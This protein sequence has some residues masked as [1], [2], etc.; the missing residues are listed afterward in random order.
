MGENE[1]VFRPIFGNT[2]LV[3]AQRNS[4]RKKVEKVQCLL[5]NAFFRSH[6]EVA[7]HL[8]KTHK[9]CPKC[10]IKLKTAT[11]RKNHH[12]FC[13]RRF[14]L[15]IHR[16][17]RPEQPANGSLHPPTPEK[18]KFYNCVLCKKSCAS[19]DGLRRHQ[20]KCSARRVSKSWCLK[21]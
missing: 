3:R 10:H 11:E 4:E 7:Q 21:L 1:P 16:P 20:K 6:L 15:R 9:D 14:G 19:Q 12:K 17:Q 8:N 18:K 13:S 2:S 5:C